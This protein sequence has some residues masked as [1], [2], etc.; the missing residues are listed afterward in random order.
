MINSVIFNN[1]MAIFPK[2]M[3]KCNANA[4]LSKIPEGFFTEI[5]SL[6]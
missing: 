4:V 6:F 1:M 2:L 5:A 3:Y